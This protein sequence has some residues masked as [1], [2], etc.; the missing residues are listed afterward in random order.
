M[1]KQWVHAL[2]LV[3][4]PA[5]A[6]RDLPPF[7]RRSL[8]RLP[9]SRGRADRRAIGSASAVGDALRRRIVASWRPGERREAGSVER[10]AFPVR[11]FSEIGARV[12]NQSSTI[13][14]G[15]RSPPQPLEHQSGLHG[16]RALV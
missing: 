9:R 14:P 15:S 11:S 12:G 2:E 13:L 10:Y 5:G 7:F 4:A 3:A 6:E 8:Q 1:T 16:V